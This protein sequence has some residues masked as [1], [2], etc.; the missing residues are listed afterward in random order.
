MGVIPPEL[1]T[2]EFRELW[3]DWIAHR[4]GF[5]RIKPRTAQATLKRL[6]EYGHDIA[7]EAIDEAI[8]NGWVRLHPE[9]V[10]QQITR[11]SAA[12]GAM[13]LRTFLES[14]KP[15]RSSVV[16]A[17]DEMSRGQDVRDSAFPRL[18]GF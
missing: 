12:R 8:S 14:I 16:G 3:A 6:A 4:K 10:G 13:D 1:D 18:E 2:E 7:I 15:P 11:R 17:S 9:L 5:K